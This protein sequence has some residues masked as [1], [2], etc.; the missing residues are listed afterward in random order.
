MK[1]LV[2]KILPVE[3]YDM[4]GLEEWLA[5]MAARG[6]HLVKIGTDFARFAPGTPRAGVRYALDIKAWGDIDKERNELYAQAGWEFVTTLKGL[7]Y[8][9]RTADPAAPA[10]HTDPMT[11]SFTFDRLLRRSRWTPFILLAFALF[12]WRS[13]FADFFDNPWI[14]PNSFLLNT[15]A[16]CLILA[17]FVCYALSLFR[18]IRWRHALKVLQ[19]QLADGIPLDEGRRWPRRFFLKEWAPLILWLCAALVWG[20]CIQPKTSKQLPL[21]EDWNFPRVSLEQ[22]MERE[23]VVNLTA[24]PPSG[25]LLPHPTWRRSLLVPEQISFQQWGT[26]LLEDGSAQECGVYLHLYRLRF[27]DMAPLLLRCLQEDQLA[28]WRRYEKNTGEYHINSLLAEFYINS[29]LAEFSGFQSV[30]HPAFDALTVLTW[31]TENMDA[32]RKLY[33]GQIGNLVFTLSCS[34]PADV[35]LALE[36]FVKEVTK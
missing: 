16:A 25:R 17:L 35:D 8:V 22:V 12:S 20:F 28:W 2:W 23:D 9:Y 27:P 3:P 36:I 1:K 21:P 29:P 6:L 13:I 4:R 10:L 24:E 26:A 19:K 11:Q 15:E 32:P 18:S 14:L 34:G 5:A 7:Y 30:D 33:A 31:R